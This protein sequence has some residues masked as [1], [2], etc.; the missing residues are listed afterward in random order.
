MQDTSLKELF[1]EIEPFHS[2]WLAGDGGHTIYVEQSGN[3]EGRPIIFLHGGPGGGTGARQRRFFDPAHY[4]IILFDQRGCGKS[5]P[6]GETTNNTTA[7][8]IADMEAIRNHLNIKEWILFGGSWGSSLAL[9]YGVEYPAVTMGLILRGV[10]LS[11]KH[12][13]EWFLNDVDL[14]FPELHANLINHKPYIN[15]SNLVQ[16]YI[17]LVFADDREEAKKAA[18]MWNTFE[19]SIL[20]MLPNVSQGNAGEDVDRDFELARARV[21]LHYIKHD[22]FMDGAGIL[23]KLAVLKDK[24]VSIVQG[25]YDM[26]CPPKTAYEVARLLPQ[27]DLIMVPDAGHSASEAGT[28][29]GLI[30]ATEK[31][32]SL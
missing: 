20:K 32:K 13:L 31:F 7:H 18:V 17:D 23:Q 11:R 27:S 22:C 10:F 14:F 5:K 4:R 6:L 24:P 9:A 2:E 3:P 30:K 12:E 16:S 26:V 28:L 29:D 19:G 25:R 15:K 1:P 21:Q 8:L